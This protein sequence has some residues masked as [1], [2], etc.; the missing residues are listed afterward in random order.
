MFAPL[1]ARVVVVPVASRR[2]LPPEELAAAFRDVR[3]GLDVTV[4]GSVGEALASCEGAGDPLILVAGSLY[5][6]GEAMERL[7]VLPVPAVGE[8]GLNE[9]GGRPGH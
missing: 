6:V 8:R 4:A 7:G 1:A 2:G 3:P 5:L 9:W